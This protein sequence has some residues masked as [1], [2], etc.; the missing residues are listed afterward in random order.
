MYTCL[1]KMKI[2]IVVAHPDD[3]LYLLGTAI[4]HVR[5]KD[6]VHLVISTNGEKQGDPEQRRKDSRN[7]GNKIKLKETIFLNLPDTKLPQ[8]DSL[9]QQI[10]D[11]INKIKPDTIYTLYPEDTHQDHRAVS[12]AVQAA[13]RKSKNIIFFETPSTINFIPN[14]FVDITKFMDEKIKRLK[15]YT[16]QTDAWYL[17]VEAIK[18]ISQFRGFQGRCKYAEAFNILRTIR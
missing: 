13:G 12:R 11:L 9:I 5:D 18:G 17:E 14:H 2:L 15:D 6:E 1:V 16:P 8:Q 7:C 4:K 10:E 3:E